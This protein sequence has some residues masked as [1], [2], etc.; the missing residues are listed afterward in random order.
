MS[1]PG[2]PDGRPRLFL[3]DF[4]SAVG[5]GLGWAAPSPLPAASQSGA[6]GKGTAVAVLPRTH[7]CLARSPSPSLPRCP[8]R[9][10]PPALFRKNIA[11]KRGWMEGGE[12]SRTEVTAPIP[13]TLP[14]GSPRQSSSFRQAAG[15]S[16]GREV[17]NSA[18]GCLHL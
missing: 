8:A 5:I 4:F 3:L 9:C 2:F 17:G 15:R 10:T 6:R 13:Q 7:R 14:A 18:P 16:E 11:V 12:K 1:G